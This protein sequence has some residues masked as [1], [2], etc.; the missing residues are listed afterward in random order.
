MMAHPRVL[1]LQRPGLVSF[2]GPLVAANLLPALDYQEAIHVTRVLSMAGLAPAGGMATARPFRA[3]HHTVS[4]L[5]MKG[6]ADRPGEVALASHGVLVL[7][8][9]LEFRKSVLEATRDALRAHPV[10]MVIALADPCAC[11]RRT[12]GRQECRCTDAERTRYRARLDAVKT[13]LELTEVSH[14]S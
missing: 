2:Q 14:G 9:V 1:L 13:L 4:D 11:I 3:P 8:E 12:M 6:K 10:R 5:A 7:D